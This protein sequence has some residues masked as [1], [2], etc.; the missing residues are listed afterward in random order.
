MAYQRQG[1]ESPSEAAAQQSTCL[2]AYDKNNQHTAQ[3]VFKERAREPS[4]KRHL[5]YILM[6]CTFADVIT[7]L[8]KCQHFKSNPRQY[9][10]PGCQKDVRMP[11][12]GHGEKAMLKF[13]R[14]LDNVLGYPSSPARSSS[15]VSSPSS[16]LSFD[17]GPSQERDQVSPVSYLCGSS[18]IDSQWAIQQQLLPKFYNYELVM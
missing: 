7:H 8:E 4:S 10:C 17:A 12:R 6:E 16:S 1:L 11:A 2:Q 13:R 14:S 15:T 3:C 5:K 18:E 9:T